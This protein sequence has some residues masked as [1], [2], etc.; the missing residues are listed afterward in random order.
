MK[1]KILFII[2]GVIVSCSLFGQKQEKIFYDKDWNV[3]TQS[4]AEY[5]RLITIDSNGKPIGKVFDYYLTGELQ[6]EGS[7][8]YFTRAEDRKN[9]IE[10][11][12]IWYYKNG[13]KKRESNMI[14]GKEEGQ[15]T[16]W[17]ENGQKARETESKNGILNGQW[18]DYHEN[19][20]LFRKI[21]FSND[22]MADKFFV[23]CDEFGKCQNVFY[24]SFYSSDNINQWPLVKNGK[25]HASE[26]VPEKGL[27]MK[28]KTDVGFKQIIHYPLD[29]EKQFSIETIVD[30]K[31]GKKNNGHGLIWG[32]K[33]GDNYYYFIISA[34]GYYT[35]GAKTEGLNLQLK[36]WTQTNSINQ[37]KQRNQLKI[38]KI[39]DKMYFS[40]NGQLVYS[41][42][43]YS[44][45]GNYI[46]YWIA[47]GKKEIVF[48]NLI[49]KQDI[50]NE[51]ISS[52]TA[53][54]NSDWKGNGS[55]FFI[56]D[57][58]Y[59]ATNYHVIE[60]ATD[61]EIEFI[62][63]GQR[64]I[65]KAQIIQNDKQNDLAVLKITDSSFIPFLNL[66]YN[67]QINS[68]DVGTNVFALGYPIAD[69]MGNEIKFTDGKL[70]SKTGIQGD[71]SVYQISVPIQAGNSGG[72]LFDYD[73][74]LI[75]ITSG[76]LNRKYF[77][78][79]NVN[80]AIKSSYLKNLID[81][82]PFSVKLP[83]D[84]TITNKTLTEKIKIL[85]DYVV[86]IKIK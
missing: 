19:G 51:Y 30:F 50:D 45:R 44:F 72:P 22:K 28:T 18:I 38:L 46:G 14:A 42:D 58:G 41:D 54:S 34:N 27:L 43:F 40:I 26:I 7:F 6:W 49:I 11:V 70:S 79:E 29:L 2:I 73:G 83:D 82:L 13:K 12:C 15:T 3:C 35:I 52:N 63:D 67:F 32:F 4:K 9:I 56:D 48:E 53:N 33:D 60:E 1:Q 75:G 74:N 78:S 80:Y 36:E 84:K 8:S 86:L 85:S 61:I 77:D 65:Y 24:E 21:N 31:K 62:R 57:R 71:V 5:Y 68:S 59:I 76:G 81:V 39:K 20:K 23:E 16:Y 66:P 25:N 55:G 47:S 69:V 10:G 64:Q 37:N 17:Y